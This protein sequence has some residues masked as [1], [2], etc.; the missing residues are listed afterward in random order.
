M[1]E[2]ELE[3]EMLHLIAEMQ[4]LTDALPTIAEEE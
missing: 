4:E 2:Q 3:A 1:S